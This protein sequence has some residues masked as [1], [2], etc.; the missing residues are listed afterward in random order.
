MLK[1]HM[2]EH[3]SNYEEEQEDDKTAKKQASTSASSTS[4]S[5]S[6]STFSG[7]SQQGRQQAEANQIYS[8]TNPHAKSSPSS[9]AD[10]KLKGTTHDL[11]ELLERVQSSRLDDQRCVLPPYIK[12]MIITVK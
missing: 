4:S 6:S 2:L 5:S 1:I 9:P 8:A 11:F 3:L 10:E 7:A 12:Q